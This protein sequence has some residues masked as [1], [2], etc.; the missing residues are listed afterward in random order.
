[1][2]RASGIEDAGSAGELRLVVKQG[3]TGQINAERL[4]PAAKVTVMRTEGACVN[5][6]ATNRADAFLYDQLSVLGAS[7][8]HAE[9]TKAL[10]T[11]LT[12]EPYAMAVPH[13]DEKMLARLNEFL[14]TIREDG[15][16]GALRDQYLKDLPDG[17]K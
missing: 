17:S 2:N 8:A 3:T 6:V 9:T 14:E 11:P 10:L 4:F 5:E 15:R 7:K 13:G 12:R 1:M 16:Y